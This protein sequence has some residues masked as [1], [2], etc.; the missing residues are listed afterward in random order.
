MTAPPMKSVTVGGV[1]VRVKFGDIPEWG[2]YD[3]YAK[4]ITISTEATKR[5]ADF[6]STL[7]HEM[8]H[9]SLSISGVGFLDAYDE[10][11]IVRCIETIFFPAWERTLKRL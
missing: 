11:A 6:L 7:R 8:I 10:E 1:K 3:H 9:A 5:K 2:L 4:C